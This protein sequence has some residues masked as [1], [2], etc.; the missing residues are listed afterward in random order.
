MEWLERLNMAM[1]YI[2]R[3]MEEGINVD[4]AARI[5]CCSPFHFQRMF[6]YIAG[7]PLSEYVRRRR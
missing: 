2:E 5:A 4:E 3:G 1:D 6:S 7:L